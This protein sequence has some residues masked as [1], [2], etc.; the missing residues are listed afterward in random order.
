MGK[1]QPPGAPLSSGAVPGYPAGI[2]GAGSG[3]A[4][5][6]ESNLTE[7]RP[8]DLLAG[9]YRI[10]RVLGRGGMGVVVA[11]IHETLDERVALKFLLPEALQSREAAERFLREARAAVKIRSEHV[12]RV[13][14]VGTLESGAPYMVMEYLDGVDLARYVENTGPLAVEEALEY[15]LQACEALAEAHSLG[16]VHRDLKPANLFRIQRADGTPSVKLLDFGISKIS[17]PD[18]SITRTS[19][20]MGSPLYMA[21][22][23]MTSAKNVDARADIWA[24]GII[25]YELLTGDVPFGGETIPEL[26]AKILTE[27]PQP[28]R[29]RRPDVTPELERVILR[30]LEKDRERRYGS[31]AD[32]AQEL[33]PFAPERAFLSIE[34]VS[35]V[36][37]A[38]RSPSDHVVAPARTNA[39]AETQA[40]WGETA[41]AVKPSGGRSSLGLFV[42]MGSALVLVA[43]GALAFV[44]FSSAGAEGGSES[45]VGEGL[46][47]AAGEARGETPAV[48]PARTGAQPLPALEPASAPSETGEKAEGAPPGDASRGDAE[49]PNAGDPSGAPPKNAAATPESNPAPS[50]A[51]PSK[52]EPSK[53]ESPKPASSTTT[54]TTTS[55]GASTSTTPRTSPA[56]G[57][58]AP[59]RTSSPPTTTGAPRNDFYLDRK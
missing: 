50:K 16:I 29:A 46:P 15:V 57:E 14:D 12:A 51:E 45:P 24:L 5:M 11:A 2:L 35:R 21:P 8:G 7:V 4:A 3:S 54:K 10:E 25:L 40:A 31:V 13:T 43:G 39:E 48:V 37:G 44:V 19:S 1:I 34:R 55:K 20:M 6:S 38:S 23:Q 59:A 36:L 30:C 52:A 58:T 22:E 18:A 9:K 33:R 49:S 28:L 53:S 56:G 32:L 26:C 27:A 17:S 42:A 41:N 47:D